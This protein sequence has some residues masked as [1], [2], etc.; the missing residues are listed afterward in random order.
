MIL[1]VSFSLKISLVLGLPI[2]LDASRP[3]PER[4]QDLLDNMTIEEKIGQ[5][6]EVLRMDHMEHKFATLF[7]GSVGHVYG[8]DMTIIFNLT[9]GMRL[10]IPGLF[11]NNAMHGNANIVGATIFPM[12][13]GMSCS[14]D[15]DIIKQMAIVTAKELNHTGHSTVLGPVLCVARDLRWGRVDETFGEDSFLIGEFGAAMVQG[16]KESN[17]L[18][19]VKHYAAY[20]ETRGGFDASESDASLK[21]MHTYF[22]PQFKRAVEAGVGMIM[23]G[24]HSIEGIPCVINKYLQRD[25]LKGEWNYSGFIITDAAT[26]CALVTDHRIAGNMED[27]AIMTVEGGTDMVMYCD[28]FHAGAVSAVRKGRL[29][30]KLVN[31]SVRRLLKAKFELGLFENDR[32]PDFSKIKMG[33]PEHRAIALEACRKSLVLLKNDGILP[34]KAEEIKSIALLG[35]NADN[36]LGMFGDWWGETG[37][38]LRNAT[39]TA[40]DALVKRLPHARI[41][42]EAG[43]VLEP[44]DKANLTAAIEAAKQAEII[45]VVIGDRRCFG[46]EGHSLASMDLQG[47]QHPLLTAIAALGKKFIINVVA[48]KPL[49]IPEN[50]VAKASAIITQFA[51]GNMGGQ[52]FAEAI[53]GDYSPSGRLTVSWPRHSGQNP[54][55][56]NQIRGGHQKHYADLSQ[57]PQWSFGHGLTYS[58]VEYGPVTLDRSVYGMNDVIRI[59]MN[60]TNKGPFDVVEV[61]QFYIHD[62]VTS[63]TWMF[64]ELKAFRRVPLKAGETKELL[65]E[66]PVSNCSIVTNEGK[67]VVEPGQMVLFVSKSFAERVQ[68]APF[69]IE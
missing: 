19:C 51:P 12:Q 9:R 65:V 52:A 3:I 25:L 11:A 4:I 27:A 35:P 24:Y 68:S 18:S 8:K 1:L 54:V 28:L 6:L 32:Y 20:S 41:L 50:I 66:I 16:Y 15:T 43:A 29:S 64:A 49:V 55:Y 14:W 5:M 23:S 38:P 48:G 58:N 59:K 63:V 33:T 56:Y 47:T 45:I 60:V 62:V 42:Y 17:I 46:E 44:H 30:E 57:A 40:R 39:I 69:V 13:L 10:K 31:D 22:L 61:V 37:R 26:S 2:Y 67:R 34:L 53:V 7:P 36:D 21:K